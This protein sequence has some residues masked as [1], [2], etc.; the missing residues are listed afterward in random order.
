M[1]IATAPYESLQ[2]KAA[3]I[4]YRVFGSSPERLVHL[5]RGVMTLKFAARLPGGEW[6]VV[7]FYPPTR[8]HVLDYEPDILRRCLAMGVNVPRVVAD[9]RDEPEAGPAYVV[10]RMIQG[11]PLSLRYGRMTT[12]GRTRIGAAIVE[13]LC[14]LAEISVVG[15][16]DL[17]NAFSAQFAS[18]EEFVE[19]ALLEGV[20]NARRHHLLP[21]NCLDKLENLRGKLGG[22][23]REAPGVLAWGDIALDNIL[24]N[25]R[26]SLAG[27][28]DFEGALSG[29]PLLNLG[30]CYSRYGPNTF[31]ETLKDNWLRPLNEADVRR[32]DLYA[33]LRA[34]RLLKFAHEPLPYGQARTPITELLPGFPLALQGLVATR[35]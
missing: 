9:S 25:D 10:Y 26:D 1:R 8:A 31:F 7:R 12:E 14:A 35:T 22:L 3:S 13:T 6:Y 32:I 11:T 21:T 16:G 20:Y 19:S 33:V 15:Y 23:V 34:L 18:F 4:I 17:L 24:V 28:V 30:Y 2:T 27:L 5:N 29:E